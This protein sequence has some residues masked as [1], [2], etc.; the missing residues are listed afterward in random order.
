MP[1]ILSTKQI[2]TQEA[3]LFQ[4]DLS[5][6][7]PEK[8]CSFHYRVGDLFSKQL[9]NRPQVSMDYLVNKPLQAAGMSADNVRG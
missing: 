1:S 7:P 3:T 5:L 6:I 2:T 9:S 4:I 8:A